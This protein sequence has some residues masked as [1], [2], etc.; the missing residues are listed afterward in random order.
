LEKLHLKEG[1]SGSVDRSCLLSGAQRHK[2]I[3]IHHFNTIHS[4][5]HA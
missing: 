2:D 1:A 4:H 5:T 3:G